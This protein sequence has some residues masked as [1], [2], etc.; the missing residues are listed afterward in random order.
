MAQFI[1]TT[2]SP[3]IIQAAE[4]NQIVAL[5][6]QEGRIVARELPMSNFG[7]RG[8]TLDEVL[9]DVMGMTDTRTE[10]FGELMAQF[11]KAI[12][13]EDHPGAILAYEQLDMSLHPTSHMRKL[14][15]LQLAAIASA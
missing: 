9:T 4:P 1:V 10:V 8:W 3:H 14:L 5:E 13:D 6:N 12:D 2:H 11:N 7:F 15:R